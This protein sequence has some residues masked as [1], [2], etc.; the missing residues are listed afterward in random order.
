MIKKDKKYLPLRIISPGLKQNVNVFQ[1]SWYIQVPLVALCLALQWS[2]ESREAEISAASPGYQRETSFVNSSP[3]VS[4]L[5]SWLA[6]LVCTTT[7]FT[8]NL[9]T[10]FSWCPLHLLVC[11]L[12]LQTQSGT[13]HRDA[14]FSQIHTYTH[15]QQHIKDLGTYTTNL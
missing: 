15:S 9:C 14:V 13:I 11:V 2:T 7:L 4:R 8:S 10:A 1:A 5:Y 12:K 3:T 6:A